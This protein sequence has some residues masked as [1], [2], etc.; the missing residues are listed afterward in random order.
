MRYERLKN[1]EKA[2]RYKE[3]TAENIRTASEG[4]RVEDEKQ[5]GVLNSH[6]DEMRKRN[7]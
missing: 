3:R 2:L 7:M 4:G 6:N 5:L 1:R